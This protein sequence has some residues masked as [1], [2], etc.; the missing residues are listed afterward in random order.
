LISPAD[1]V[2]AAAV[3]SQPQVASSA[4]LAPV[5][6][7]R[8][9][10]AAPAPYLFAGS[11]T[12]RGLTKEVF[13]F[14][15]A[16]S[17]GDPTFGYPSWN[18]NVLSTVAYFSI[19]VR[20]DGVIGGAGWSVFDSSVMTGLVN[21]AHAHGVKVVVTLTGPGA[22]D[23]CDA[24]YNGLTTAQQ[25]VAQVV[26]KNLD[27]VNIDYEG[28]L[29]MCHPTNPSLVPQTNQALLT[30]FAQNLRTTLDNTRP[31]YYLSI[32]TYSGSGAGNDGF[33][34]IPD[35]N[36]YVDSFFVMAY[37]MDYANLPFPP[38]NCSSFCMN[39]VSPLTTYNYNDTISMSQY[40]AVVGAG[41]VILGQPYYGRV[42]CVASPVAHA[43]PIGS[44]GAASYLDAAAAI[45]S[46]D[47]KPGT[48]V[49][50]RDANDP[51]GLDRWDTWYDN[52]LNCWREMYWGDVTQLD[53]RYTFV[54]QTGLRGVGFWTL[55]YGG[56]AAELWNALEVNFVH[57]VDASVSST[58]TDLTQPAGSTIAFSAASDGCLSPLYEFWVQYPNGTWNLMQGWGSTGTFSWNTAGLA[59]GVYTIHAWAGRSTST[60]DSIGAATVTL[61]GCTSAT[62]SPS[63]VSQPAGSGV[64]FTPGSGGGCPTP[65]Y[66]YWVLYPNGTWNL[67]QAWTPSPSYS[68]D[69]TG[70]APGTYTVH[71]W[72]GQQGAA[73]TL[74]VYASATVT[75]TGCTS[76][77][78]T[79]PAISQAAGTTVN[80]TAGATPCPNPQFEFYVL[81]PDGTWNLKQ[82][83]GGAAFNWDT[84]GL[85]PGT[86]TVHAWA[87]QTAASTATYETIGA[88]TV[89][90]TG[91]TL[92]TVSPP[93]GSGAVGS[94]PTFTAGS[95]TCP[96]PTYEF[97]VQYPDGT[98]YQKQGFSTTAT[99]QW[100][101]TG[102]A[103]GK[104]VIHAWVN[105]QG[106]STSTYET[107][108]AATYTVT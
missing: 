19:S 7:I 79:P 80:L 37:D 21:T 65:V 59:P 47:I 16:S 88:G 66:E 75:L 36:K 96:T 87:N 106:A 63:T 82:G 104:Y 61:T 14:A 25:I 83:W 3:R 9:R 20:Y 86:Y 26:A 97:W 13:G 70:L 51:S 15:T 107:I 76:G 52:S 95:S 40:S 89:T 93:S 74:E 22:A 108:G 18:F 34:N 105:N 23:L 71:A 5:G 17:L 29:A 91:C 28:Q 60:W 72:A 30:K 31:G 6:P 69:T 94:K 55:N 56:G 12:N 90:L 67:R 102:L 53:T 24:L 27:G 78:V 49:I 44:P 46:P 101:T 33:F 73:S 48:Y 64:A 8:S 98:W 4:R 99:W 45:S 100:D 38:L 92:G 77:S 54:N 81:Y 103:K 85:A 11:N 2:S 57:C 84:S 10:S 50:H 41:K 35:L 39:P 58:P 62:L 32:D 1:P 68:W 43:A 42:A